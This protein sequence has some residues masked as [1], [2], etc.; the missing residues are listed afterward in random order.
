ME[1][2]FKQEIQDG[3]LLRTF[4]NGVDEHELKWHYDLKD[5]KVQVIKG[6][7]WLL[8]IDNQ[9]PETLTPLKEY[10]IPK[11][12]YHRVIKGSGDLVVLIEEFN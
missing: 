8:Q 4:S 12:V 1:F 3:K 11:G 7:N 10:F 2:P 6:D 5:R 9:L